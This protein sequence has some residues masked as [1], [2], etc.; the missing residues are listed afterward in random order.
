MSLVDRRRKRIAI[1]IPSSFVSDTPHLREK[2]VRVGFLAR[3]AAIFRIEEIMI[4]PP[5]PGTDR[6]EA[7]FLKKI[8]TYMETPQYLRRKMFPLSSEMR[9]VGVL[10]PLRT[11]HHPVETTN[12]HAPVAYR[13]GLALGSDGVWATVDIGRASPIRIKA[14]GLKV[15]ARVTLR[16]EQTPN[17]ERLVVVSRDEV[18][19]YWGYRVSLLEKPLGETLRQ[20]P[21]D[22]V[23][24]T[25]KYGRSILE[26]L[27]KLKR[28]LATA[29]GVIVAFGS[30]QE[31]L[32]EILA[33][34]GTKPEDLSGF[35]LNTIPH[36]GTETVRTE[37]AV[38]ATLSILN[39]VETD[40][41]ANLPA[42]AGWSLHCVR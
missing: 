9:Y 39:L 29:S 11:P 23:V 32:R 33:R 35:V 26:S 2:T 16:I 14:P 42:C 15:S 7:K 21:S 8:L 18:P 24:M 6:K 1:A 12:Q 27:S 3:A 17:G 40:V 13:E 10:P 4:Y 34:E 37:E 36:Q 38:Y 31:G 41:R 5:V 28:D 19:I 22:L 25:S 20:R 30:P